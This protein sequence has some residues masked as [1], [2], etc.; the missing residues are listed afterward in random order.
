MNDMLNFF[1]SLMGYTADWLF[2]EP[3]R[4]FTGILIGA[5]VIGLIHKIIKN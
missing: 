3:I 4:Y 2:L 1:T 5:C